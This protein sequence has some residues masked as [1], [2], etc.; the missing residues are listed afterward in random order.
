MSSLRDNY[1]YEE[2]TEGGFKVLPKG[3][4]DFT[5]EEVFEW[6]ESKKGNDMLPICILVEGTKQN[7]W[8][9]FTE[10]AKWRIDSFLKSIYNGTLPVGKRMDFNN[11]SWM[12]GRSGRVEL[13]VKKIP[14]KN[15]Q[16][17]ETIEVNEILRYVYPKTALEGR[18]VTTPA[19]DPASRPRPGASPAPADDYQEEDD[20][21]F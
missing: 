8:L 18:T 3:E 1:V 4:Y 5:V 6:E 20:V 7:D 15:G 21:P 16:P 11:T 17:G 10:S 13:G 14:K 19:A 9:T 12:Q 2:P